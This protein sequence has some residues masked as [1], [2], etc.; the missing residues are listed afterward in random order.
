M[1]P[2]KCY[3][4]LPFKFLKI[5]IFKIF[6]CSLVISPTNTGAHIVLEVKLPFYYFIISFTSYRVALG[7]CPAL[8]LLCDFSYMNRPGA[9]GLKSL[10]RLDS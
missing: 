3:S 6:V 8:S 2:G 10:E 1:K 9:A 5:L 4:V 7:Q